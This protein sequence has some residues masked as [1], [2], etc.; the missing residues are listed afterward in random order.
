MRCA[1][2]H[3]V[4]EPRW[5]ACA[6]VARTAA[7]RRGRQSV[8][9][10]LLSAGHAERTCRIQ[11]NSARLMEGM[12]NAC[13]C[14]SH[15]SV[16]VCNPAITGLPARDA[17]Q[18]SAETCPAACRPVRCGGRA[19]AASSS[20]LTPVLLLSAPCCNGPWV[21]RDCGRWAREEGARGERRRAGAHR[22]AVPDL[23]APL[24]A[25][26]GPADAGVAAGGPGRR[27][28]GAAGAPPA[29]RRR[30]RLPA[31]RARRARL[32]PRRRRRAAGR[33]AWRRRAC[34][35]RARPSRARARARAEPGAA[36]QALP[37][38]VWA[39]LGAL[40]GSGGALAGGRV[41]RRA[42]GR[43]SVPAGAPGGS[44]KHALHGAHPCSVTVFNMTTS[45]TERP[46][47]VQ[48][49][50]LTHALLTGTADCRAQL[51]GKQLGGLAQARSP[52][53]QVPRYRGV[54][55]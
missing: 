55:R 38:R 52:Q 36:G 29:R 7:R 48:R 2:H 27:G 35:R 33:H 50:S 41:R 46:T 34:D 11:S 39:G 26:R 5:G 8:A 49:C 30:R 15:K 13:P 3:T 20:P 14:V 43:R 45:D 22:V 40:R 54:I 28:A 16:A 42:R 53:Q 25:A 18:A 4:K 17:C 23:R 21:R 24:A 37:F 51:Q 31:R 9:F 19:R 44:R 6:A 32:G 1:P 10:V 12:H 47:R